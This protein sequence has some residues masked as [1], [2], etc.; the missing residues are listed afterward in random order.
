MPIYLALEALR[1][2]VVDDDELMLYQVEMKLKELGI[3]HFFSCNSGV[4]ALRHID[5]GETFNVLILDLKMP[6]M[7]GI[8]VLRKLALRHFKGGILLFSGEDERILKTAQSLALAHELNVIGTLAKPVSSKALKEKLDSYSPTNNNGQRSSH[9]EINADSLKHAIKNGD[10]HPYYQ[11]KVRIDDKRLASVEVLSRWNHKSLGMIS[12][13]LFIATAEEEHIIDELSWSIYQQAIK[14]QG[15]WHAQ[16]MNIKMFLNLSADSLNTVDLPEK[17]AKLAN[18]HGVP[19]DHIGLEITESRLMQKLTTSLDILTRLRLKGFNLSID[20]FGTG[21][22]SLEQLALAP[23][24]EL[25]IDKAF[26]HGAD[27]DHI[28]KAILEASTHLG[29]KLNMNV[30]A[31]GVETDDD[32]DTVKK[33]GCDLVQGYITSRPMP[34]HD[35]EKWLKSHGQTQR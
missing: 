5:Q 12:P 19:C 31:E 30:V 2:I 25:K 8:E 10:I 18:E 9:F 35:F 7:D 6:E 13:T 11:P 3:K 17:I 28:S 24:N 14:Q 26:V 23:F 22:S 1:V 20:D 27:K 21:Y 4:D 16:G 29:K 15:L 33:A 34:A 32:W